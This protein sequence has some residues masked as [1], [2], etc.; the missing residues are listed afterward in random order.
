MRITDVD[1][2]PRVKITD[3]DSI[4][5]RNTDVAAYRG[6]LRMS[7][8]FRGGIRMLPRTTEDY[9]CGQLMDMFNKHP[10][11][12]GLFVAALSC[13][14]LSTLS[15]FVSS[16]SAIVYEDIIK[17]NKPNI[18]DRTAA[19]LSRFLTFAFGAVALGTTFLISVLPGTVISLFQSLMGCL[20]G[21]TCA[22]F[23][24]AV[25]FKRATTKGILVG[26]FCGIALTFWINL[27]K[28]FGDLPPNPTLPAGPTHNCDLYFTSNQTTL[29]YS[30]FET[31]SSPVVN[32]T[33]TV[34]VE[35]ELTVLE[36]IYN[37]SYM[38]ISLVGFT[39]TI[40]VGIIVSLLTT[41]PEKVDERCI[42]SFRKH[43][44][45]ELFGKDA[46]APSDLTDEEMKFLRRPTP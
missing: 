34:V 39:V 40:I 29:E 18:G 35:S 44:V 17:V 31:T 10:G 3:V 21:P 20:D 38:L 6:E 8:A 45:E 4:P 19:K 24:L 2:V 1:R 28:L 33:T 30:N 14:A 36:Q 16:L 22:I 32:A 46:T 43:I 12:P 7:T 42:F 23:I 5:R 25:G 9:G 26:T 37:I 13:A 27:G 15:S 41:P 11:I